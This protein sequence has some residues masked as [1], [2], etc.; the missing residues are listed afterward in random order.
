MSPDLQN[1]VKAVANIA[2]ASII[3]LVVMYRGRDMTLSGRDGDWQASTPCEPNEVE[4]YEVSGF[5][6][7]VVEALDE[8]A[9][10]AD[11]REDTSDDDAEDE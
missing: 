7:T 6:P 11:L 2:G 4:Q 3:G 10:E 5:G 9:D 8:C 1:A